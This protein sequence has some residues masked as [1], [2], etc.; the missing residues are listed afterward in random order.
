MVNE[1]VVAPVATFS[2]LFVGVVGVEK[3]KMVSV[4]EINNNNVRV[5]NYPEIF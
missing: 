1:V 2:R 5:Y 4:T 3:R